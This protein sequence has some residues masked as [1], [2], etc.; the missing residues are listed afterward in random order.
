MI[1][2]PSLGGVAESWQPLRLPEGGGS[3]PRSPLLVGFPPSPLFLPF[4]GP[5]EGFDS[6]RAELPQ[7][8]RRTR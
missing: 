1:S 7:S 2:R 4:P 5:D 3:I 8:W 6:P